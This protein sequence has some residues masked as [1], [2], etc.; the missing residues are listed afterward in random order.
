MCDGLQS[1]RP[2]AAAVAAVTRATSC[3]GCAKCTVKQKSLSERRK[4]L[5]RRLDSLVS[6]ISMDITFLSSMRQ[7]EPPI[8]R[9]VPLALAR[10]G[11]AV[12][13]LLPLVATSDTACART[14]RGLRELTVA[15]CAPAATECDSIMC[16]CCC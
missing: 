8:R 16:V 14:A 1:Q 11:G 4:S 2:K 10:G 12:A 9:D 13:V 7:L 15:A 3:C 6:C 5:L